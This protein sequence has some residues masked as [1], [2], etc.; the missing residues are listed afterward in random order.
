MIYRKYY[1]CDCGEEWSDDWENL[2][3]DK[4]PNCNAENEVVDYEEL[5][6]EE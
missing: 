3:N 2:C 4:C 5:E 1:E 6:E